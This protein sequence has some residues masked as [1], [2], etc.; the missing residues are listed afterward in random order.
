MPFYIP[1]LDD[2]NDAFLDIDDYEESENLEQDEL[3]EKIYNYNIRIRNVW[4]YL[5][6][7]DY[8]NLVSYKQYIIDR[9]PQQCEHINHIIASFIHLHLSPDNLSP[10][11]KEHPNYQKVID[12]VLDC[13]ECDNSMVDTKDIESIMVANDGMYWFIPGDDDD[14]DDDDI[15]TACLKDWDL[16]LN[17]DTLHLCSTDVYS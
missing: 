17:W 3:Q 1:S 5:I 13:C 11:S 7:F 16:R 8:D 2:E 12:F 15:F 9:L 6:T 14:D 10:Q 4:Y